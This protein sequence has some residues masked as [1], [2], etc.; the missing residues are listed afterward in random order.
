MLDIK[1]IKENVE[2]VKQAMLNRNKAVNF[3]QILKLDEERKFVIWEIEKL[4]LK[5]NKESGE[6][7]KLKKDGKEP[8]LDILAEI[9]ETRDIIQEQEK[10]LLMIKN[11]MED[12]L[13]GLPNIPDESVPIGKG[14]KNNKIIRIVGEIKKFSFQPKHHWEIGEKLDILDL[15]VSKKKE[16]IALS[17]AQPSFFKTAKREPEIFDAVAKSRISSFSPIS[18]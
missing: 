2:A 8:S 5:R 1:V 13:L 6:I 15:C 16:I 4:R 10:R 3:D 11:Q 18:Q 12:F 7:G 9:N 14:E 17:K